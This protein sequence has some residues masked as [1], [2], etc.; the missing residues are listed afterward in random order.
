MSQLRL[1]MLCLAIAALATPAMAARADASFPGKTPD[2]Y[3][4][5][6]TRVT[7]ADGRQLNLRCSGSGQPAVVLEAGSNADS[8]VWFKVQDAL[9]GLTRVCAYDRAGYGFSDEGPLPR[10]LDADVADLKALLDAAKIGPPVVLVGHS[11]GSNIVRQFASAHPA[12]TAGL[13]LVDPPE[14]DLG[15]HMTAK[16]K[17]DGVRADTMRD[18]FLASCLKAAEQGML[19]GPAPQ[20]QGCIRGPMPW[21]SERVNAS[22]RANKERPGYWRT[23]R[24]E[25]E[26]NETIF[27]TP[28]VQGNPHG[29]MPLVVL[30]ATDVAAAA[31]VEMREGLTAA[32]NETHRRLAASSSAG[33]LVPVAGSSHD[34]QLDQPQA[35]VDAVRTVLQ[36][37]RAATPPAK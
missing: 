20:P 29:S 32:R 2:D 7:L 22:I 12:D 10:G 3:A 18:A 19:S 36:A 6:G 17:E 14:H 11:L 25:L 5:P 15:S 28:V 24:S 9:A 34:I 23:L 13:V 33:T 1:T 30:A 26:Q 21:A 37:A 35:L 4:S 16:W 8:T 27:A 31:P